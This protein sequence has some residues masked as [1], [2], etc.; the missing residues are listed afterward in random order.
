MTAAMDI[1]LKPV[2][3][4]GHYFV[5]YFLEDVRTLHYLQIKELAQEDELRGDC[6]N[7]ESILRAE[8]FFKIVFRFALS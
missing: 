3:I 7:E 4:V 2:E 1:C 6:V 8:Y 5:K